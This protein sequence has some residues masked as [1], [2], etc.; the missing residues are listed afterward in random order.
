MRLVT[1][2]LMMR[3]RQIKNR[4]NLDVKDKCKLVNK[5]VYVINV[6][7]K[8]VDKMLLEWNNKLSLTFKSNVEKQFLLG[9][10]LFFNL[11]MV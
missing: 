5:E 2:N 1:K 6:C 9:G 8:Y 10:I 11:C 7:M 4:E 3:I